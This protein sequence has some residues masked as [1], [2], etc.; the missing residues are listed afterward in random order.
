MKGGI[1]LTLAVAMLVA[2][3]CNNNSSN[4]GTSASGAPTLLAEKGKGMFMQNC[5]SC[6]LKNSAIS[7]PAV[8]GVLSRWN[9]DSASLKAF[10]RN[11]QKL[12]ADGH[13]SAVAAA[14]KANGAMMTPWPGLTDEELNAL[15]SYMQS[16]DVN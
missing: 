6:H 9:N 3:A 11:P 10:I 1:I 4:S 15:I 7:G 13:P 12:I 16:P 2:V 14:Q 5:S 8:A